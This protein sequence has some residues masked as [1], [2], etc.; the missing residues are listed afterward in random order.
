MTSPRRAPARLLL[1]LAVAALA[2]AM[3]FALPPASAGPAPTCQ[4][5][6]ADAPLERVERD[7][8]EA[9]NVYRRERGR[10]DVAASP[11][12]RRAALWKSQER[13]RGGPE[14]H[15]DPFRRWDER[16]NDCGY[17][18]PAEKGENLAAFQGELPSDQ[19]AVLILEA[20]KRSPA[21]DQVLADPAYRVVGVARVRVPGAARTFWT[22]DFGSVAD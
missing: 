12:L 18:M 6:D 2:A 17:D 1:A 19:E 7:M 4:V 3:F 22:A 5:E 21:H 15:D 9:I 20:W 10:P 14:T 8:I 13:A 11:A 16:L